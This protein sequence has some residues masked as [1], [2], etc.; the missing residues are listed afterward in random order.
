MP[1]AGAGPPPRPV[2]A[3]PGPVVHAY[4][5]LDGVHEGRNAMASA[6]GTGHA[7]ATR[8]RRTSARLGAEQLEPRRLLTVVL[9]PH[10]QLLLE[11][12]NRARAAPAAEAERLGIDLNAGLAPGTI[13]SAAK[14]PLAPHPILLEAAGRH[15]QDMLD[16]DYFEHDNPEGQDPTARAR[17]LGYVGG[18]G[19]NI[20]WGGSTGTID[21]IAHVVARHDG[22]FRSSGHRTNLL[23]PGYREVGPAVRFGRFT[24]DGRTF[25][26]SMVAQ[27]FGFGT[28]AYLTGVAFSDTVVSDRFYTVGE[29]LSDI[30]VTATAPAGTTFTTTTGPSGGYMLPLPAGSFS[31]VF[32]RGEEATAA[33]PV[34]IAGGRNVKLDFDGMFADGTEP[35]P[36]PSPAPFVVQSFVAPAAGAYGV[37]S[38]VRV[39]VVLS[40]PARVSG[41]PALPLVVGGRTVFAA[42]AGGNGTSTLHFSYTVGRSLSAAEVRLGTTLRDHARIRATDGTRLP[43]PLPAGIA[44]DL[45]AGVS[46]DTLAPRATG[47]VTV[48]ESRAYA[49]GET[50]RFVVTFSEPVVVGGAPTL[51]L[52]VRPGN[53]AV[54]RATFT[55]ASPDGRSLA[56]EYV[57]HAG[58][59]TPTGRPLRMARTIG[60]G[61]IADAAGNAAVRSISLPTTTGIRLTVLPVPTAA[62]RARAGAGGPAPTT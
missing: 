55:A 9:T 44:G 46:I 40:A 54:R 36:P 53:A 23:E 6:D 31:V 24:T 57:V 8:R 35:P 41:R 29:G 47:V 56:F 52:H 5:R 20:A 15:A 32:S 58:D 62:G 14:Q 13:S 17:A 59:G 38:R 51:A 45:L 39:A 49:A 50:L 19:E 2:C 4:D 48:P 42:L 37:G 25:N 18:V 21:Q 60:G 27:G 12:I 3:L 11:L 10:E 33:V 1:A 26:A 61:T 7:C 22:L 28:T 34:S 43:A 30:V 16:R